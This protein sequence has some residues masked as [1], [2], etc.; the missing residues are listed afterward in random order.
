MYGGEAVAKE[1]LSKALARD[2]NYHYVT[3]L[4]LQRQKQ[5][6]ISRCL[7]F[8]APF[9]CPFP[10]HNSFAGGRPGAGSRN[11]EQTTPYTV[12]HTPRA[13]AEEKKRSKFAVF[14]GSSPRTRLAC[15]VY[16]VPH[17]LFQHGKWGPRRREKQSGHTTTTAD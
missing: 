7:F 15:L 17:A 16:W 6:S 14:S 3:E 13:R 9:S 5:P 11:G 2:H 10:K 12:Q 4:I 8:L 1:R